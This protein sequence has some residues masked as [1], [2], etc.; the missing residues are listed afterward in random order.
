MRNRPRDGSFDNS[1]GRSRQNF[2]ERMQCRSS[3]SL[4]D[5]ASA[6]ERTLS[7][8]PPLSAPLLL[9]DRRHFAARDHLNEGRKESGFAS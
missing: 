2:V 8:A 4:P 9:R 6:D 1:L 3:G 7:C 5:R